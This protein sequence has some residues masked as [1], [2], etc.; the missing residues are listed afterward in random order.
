MD[1]TQQRRASAL[2]AR[3][4]E[5]RSRTSEVRDSSIPSVSVI[6]VTVKQAARLLGTNDK[7]IRRGIHARELPVVRFGNSYSI[8]VEDLRKWFDR[9]KRTL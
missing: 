8:G 6:A 9:R 7:Q 3:L 2:T 4:R 5:A 1:N